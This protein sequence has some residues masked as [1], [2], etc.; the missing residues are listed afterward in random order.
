MPVFAT[1]E[2]ITVTIELR[3]GDVQI[4]ATDRADTHVE[5]RPSDESDESDVEAARKTRVE[6]VDGALLIRGLKSRALDFSKK[7]RSVDVLIELPAGSQVHSEMS[8]ADVRSTGVLGE[9]R[10]KASVGHYRLDRTGPLRLE[11]LGHVTVDAVDGDVDIATGTGRVHIGAVV[12]TA[13]VKNSNGH[14]DIGTVTGELRV[15]SANGDISVGRA[16][17]KVDAK[18]ANGSIRVGEIARGAVTLNTSTGD[19]EIGIAEGTAAWLDL[20]TGHG[21]VRNSLDD[22]SPGPEKSEETVE[23]RA[24]TSYGDITVR[25]S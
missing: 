7:T 13:V 4:I 14:T 15:R 12:G 9:C 16:D 23:V 17:A 25:R 18:T 21:R 3:A 5:V 19:L 22:V 20:K 2:P 24:N 6:H 1:P 11:T 8:V 10:F